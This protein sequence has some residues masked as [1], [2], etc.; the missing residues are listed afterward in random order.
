VC[1]ASLHRR[2]SH[3][4]YKTASLCPTCSHQNF[5]CPSTMKIALSSLYSKTT[6]LKH[7]NKKCSK[8]VLNSKHSNFNLSSRHSEK[9]NDYLSKSKLTQKSTPFILTYA[10]FFTIL[11]KLLTKLKSHIWMSKTQLFLLLVKKSLT[12]Y[13][14]TMSPPPKLLRNLKLPRLSSNPFLKM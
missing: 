13:L 11:K 3:E 8:T 1:S 12:I 4:F 6:P 2:S 7:L 10:L 9:L 5:Q 14:T